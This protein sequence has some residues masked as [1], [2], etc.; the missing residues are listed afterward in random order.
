V[1]ETI[2]HPSAGRANSFSDLY[3]LGNTPVNVDILAEYLQHYRDKNFLMTGFQKGF[4]LHY[5][6]PRRSR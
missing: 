6:G 3:S 5:H 4:S 1:V 2:Q